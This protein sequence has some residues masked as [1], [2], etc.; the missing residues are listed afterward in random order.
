M[1]DQVLGMI[2]VTSPPSTRCSFLSLAKQQRKIQRNLSRSPDFSH[3][4]GMSTP[5]LLHQR[6]QLHKRTQYTRL[7]RSRSRTREK[8]CIYNQKTKKNKLQSQKKIR[9]IRSQSIDPPHGDYI[10]ARNHP[11]IGCIMGLGHEEHRERRETWLHHHPTARGWTT[12]NSSQD[13]RSLFR[14]FCVSA[15]SA[16]EGL[17]GGLYIVGF[18]SKRS[19]WSEDGRH[20]RLEA[21]KGG[22]GATKESGRV[23]MAVKP[24]TY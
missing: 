9:Q 6:T 7:I 4:N 21:P 19:R 10:C 12:H 22:V 20:R 24:P 8:I 3:F 1:L 13:T 2:S 15:A 17:R 5:L 18:R 23:V 14:V 11:M 16:S